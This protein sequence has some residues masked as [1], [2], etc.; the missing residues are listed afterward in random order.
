VLARLLALSLPRLGEMRISAVN[1][2]V[3]K[4]FLRCPAPFNRKASHSRQAAPTLGRGEQGA[5]GVVK[6]LRES[7]RMLCC[8]CKGARTINVH[9]HN[10]ALAAYRRL[11][12]DGFDRVLEILLRVEARLRP[13]VD[14]QTTGYTCKQG[15]K[16][17]RQHEHTSSASIWGPWPASA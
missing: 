4:R 6:T 17:A 9:V 13:V 8:V 1:D 11:G 10:A 15:H 3:K 2:V 14:I 16:P 12:R 5:A 7:E